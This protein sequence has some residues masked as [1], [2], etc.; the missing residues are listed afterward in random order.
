MVVRER[1]FS[2]NNP[3]TSE[4]QALVTIRV[5]MESILPDTAVVFPTLCLLDALKGLNTRE[6]ED[7][8]AGSN[9][10]K[11][12]KLHKEGGI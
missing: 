9:H 3:A 11:N 5:G 2:A 12:A 8:L 7:L 1:D 6:C 4:N 10:L